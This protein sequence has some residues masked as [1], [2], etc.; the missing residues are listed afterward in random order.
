MQC[1][2]TCLAIAG[3]LGVTSNGRTAGLKGWI[4]IT[5]GLITKKLKD[6][7][8]VENLLCSGCPPILS[9]QDKC[10]ILQ[11]AKKQWCMTFGD[12]SNQLDLNVSESIICLI[13]RSVGYSWHVAQRVSF[14]TKN[15]RR[16]WLV[17]AKHYK[18]FSPSFRQR[19]I[20]SEE[21]YI[22]L[23]D[24]CG[25]VFV[26]RNAEEEYLEEC[27]EPKFKQSSV[28]IMVWRCIVEGMKG[29]LVVL[30]YPEAKGG[31]MNTKWYC[32]QVLDGALVDFYTNVKDLV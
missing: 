18:P 9:D 24:N 8:S 4:L 31:G 29:P 14:L 11:T 28:H 19:V 5:F 32:E 22:F 3:Y 15:H 25:R 6:T 23:G 17:W 7:G 27:L 1:H 16:C 2:H 30:E 20:N 10:Q 21:A 26:T 13:L 12:I